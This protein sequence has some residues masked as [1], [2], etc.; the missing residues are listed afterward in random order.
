[1]DVTS[2]RLYRMIIR[3]K[4]TLSHACDTEL[5][6]VLQKKPI[7]FKR[8]K[9]SSNCKKECWNSHV[10]LF[11]SRNEPIW[12]EWTMRPEANNKFIDV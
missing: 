8:I 2:A 11:K 12:G 4:I 7:A 1:M 10:K 3:V 6:N 9:P 5:L